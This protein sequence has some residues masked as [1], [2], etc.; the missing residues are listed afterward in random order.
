[1]AV[2]DHTLEHR[3]LGFAS[4]EARDNSP[5]Y[6]RW[7][8]H[9]AGS[10]EYHEF[11]A[12]LPEAK[13]QPNLLFAAI[14]WVMG[15]I[16]E[17]SE[18]EE[19]LRNHAPVIRQEMMNR[20]TQTNEP[21]RCA[22]LLPLLARLPQPLALIEVGASAG[23]CLFPDLYAYDYNSGV[24]QLGQNP[25]APDTPVLQCAVGGNAPLPMKRPDVVWRAGLELNPLDLQDDDT[26]QWLQT[27]IWPGQEARLDRLQ[28]AIAVAKQHK[29]QLIKG[30][31]LDDLPALL[32]QVPIG[33]TPVVFHSAVLVYVRDT[34]KRDAFVNMMLDS[35]AHWISNE[36]RSVFPRFAAKVAE[37]HPAGRFL[38]CENGKHRAW[39]GPHGQSIEWIG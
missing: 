18:L 19:A 1:M 4:Y 8:H 29:P 37:P 17:V 24:H 9:I 33:T 14:R 22:A 13:Q 38:L 34:D 7:A 30:D 23:L 3:Y 15:R 11:L 25:A 2:L 27:L 28:K 16:P 39:T 21:G 10:P 32:E 35:N 5:T 20:S 26:V 6:E 31:L 36:A 12:A